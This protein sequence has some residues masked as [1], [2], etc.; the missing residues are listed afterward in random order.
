MA[1][2]SAIPAGE[3][4]KDEELTL[5][6]LNLG[7]DLLVEKVD[8]LIDSVKALT[9]A[10]KLLSDKVESMGKNQGPPRRL[11]FPWE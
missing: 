6:E 3:D 5:F 2:V 1:K 11:S 8:D 4:K 7:Q 10:L 9:E